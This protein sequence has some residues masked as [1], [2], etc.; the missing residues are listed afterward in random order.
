MIVMIVDDRHVS[1]LALKIFTRN[2]LESD[3]E[4][5]SSFAGEDAMTAYC[6]RNS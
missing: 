4:M 6:E 3:V 1:Q 2:E 5:K